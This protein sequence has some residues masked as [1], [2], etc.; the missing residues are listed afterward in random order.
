MWIV[1]LTLR[2]PRTPVTRNPRRS[3]AALALRAASLAALQC[4]GCGSDAAPRPPGAKAE[5]PSSPVKEVTLVPV[6]EAAI[7]QTVDI[8]GTL[9]ADEQ[10]TVGAKVPGRL[11]SIAVDLASPVERGQIIARLETTDYALRIEQAA[12]ALAQSRAQLGLPPDGPD[13]QLDIEGT[14][15]VRQATAT[16]KE[17]DANRTRARNLAK[18]GLMT[19]M[20]L[21]AAE[22][23]AVR[24]EAALQTAREE[25]RIREAT[26]RQRRSELRMAR[27]QLDDAIVRSPLD[28]IVQMRRASVG[29]FLGAGAPIADLVRIDPLRLRVAIPELDASRVQKGQPV[30]VVLP[31]EGA[32]HAGT[33]SRLAPA[34]DQQS[35]T[36]LV[37]SDL[38]NP[39]HLRPGSLVSAQIVVSSKPMPTVPTSAIIH[40]AGLSKV[41]TVED[42]KAREKQVTIGKASGDRTEILSGVAVGDA[43]VDRPR[44]L[45]QGQAVRVAGG[46]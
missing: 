4:L 19:G 20:D 34:L 32:P 12:A 21:D 45:Q 13:E 18:E 26:I 28:G 35:R 42:G 38:K 29:Q 30:R 24:A 1:D 8:S 25:V 15:L 11:A 10:V 6:T 9:D 41:I 17:A 14:A 23:A 40:F 3:R 16:M 36:L 37:E 2:R 44:S 39:G 27:Q 5:E 46:P 33:V 22:A 31:G 43:V 7:E